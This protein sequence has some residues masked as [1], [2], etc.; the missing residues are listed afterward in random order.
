VRNVRANMRY[1]ARAEMSHQKHWHQRP[2]E[3]H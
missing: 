1:E 3:L 2:F